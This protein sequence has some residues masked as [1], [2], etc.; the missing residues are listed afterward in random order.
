MDSCTR[1]RDSMENEEST[2]MSYELLQ[3]ITDNFSEKRLLGSGTF[4]MVYKGTYTNGK[5]I[6]VKVLRDMA[7]LDDKDFKNEFQNLAK[8]DH[9]NIVQLVGYCNES[10][11]HVVEQDGRQFTAQKLHKALCFEYVDNGSLNKYISDETQGLQWHIRYKIIKGICDGLKHLHKGLETPVLHLDLKPHN[12]LL[13]KEMVPKIADFGLSRIIGDERTRQTLKNDLGTGGYLPPEYT[14]FQLLSPAFDIFSLGIIITK[15]MVGKERYNDIADMQPRKLVKLVHNNW[16]KRLQEIVRPRSLEVY[17]QQVKTCIEVASKC[18]TEDRHGRPKIQEIINILNE[19]EMVNIPLEIEEIHEFRTSIPSVQTSER[20]GVEASRSSIS[21]EEV[22]FKLL[23]KITDGFSDARLIG[24]GSSG[25]VYKGIFEDEQVIAVRI[26]DYFGGN[27]DADWVIFRDEFYNLSRIKHENIVQL[28]AY[29]YEIEEKVVEYNGRMVLAEKDNIAL[30]WEYLQ[31]GSLD[32]Y[33]SDES[34]GL[35]WCTRYKIIRGTC[36]GLRYLHEVLEK[37]I[38]HLN[39]KP[40]NILLDANMVPKIG[41][42]CL[43]ILFHEGR[44]LEAIMNATGSLGYLPPEYINTGVI[45]NKHDIFSLGVMILEMVTGCR[46]YPVHHYESEKFIELILGKWRK[47]MQETSKGR[48]VKG[49]SRQVKRCMEIALTCIEVNRHKRPNIGDIVRALDETETWIDNDIELLDVHPLELHFPFKPKRHASCLLQL[50]NRQELSKLPK[51]HVAFRLVPESPQK[52]LSQLPLGGIVPPGC[53]Y[54]LALTTCKHPQRSALNS[55]DSFVLQSMA[56]RHCNYLDQASV[57]RECERIFKKA[58]ET[59]EGEVQEVTLKSLCAP[60]AEEPSSSTTNRLEIEIV[61]MLDAQRVSSVE[62]HPKKPWIMTTHQGGNLRVWNYDTLTIL[63]LVEVP[64]QP[65]HVARFIAREEWIVAGDNNG[66]IHVISYDEN[67]DDMSFN[68]HSGQIMSLAVHPTDSYI[69]SSSH[70]DH[71]I[72]LW[73]WDKFWDFNKGAWECTRT[74]EGHSN[75]VSQVVFNQDTCSFAST[76]WDGTVK[77]W[78]LNSDVCDATLDGHLDGLLCV[79]YITGGDRQYL[80]AGS[81]DGTAQI[82]DLEIKRRR[83]YLQGHANHISVVYSHHEHQKLITGSL[84]GTV[85]IWDATTFR[86][87]NII[88]FNLGAVSDVG[89]IEEL[90]RIVVGCHQG[91]A[92]MMVKFS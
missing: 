23:E 79:D 84:D 16:K 61:A 72:K 8:L 20:D 49:Y 6:A 64:D 58:R 14:K 36:N 25:R 46:E 87:E 15:I 83:E 81:M 54:I 31:N 43:S 66:S 13:D 91:I 65:V 67:K 48:S 40:S 89:Y 35:D 32:R 51:S 92:T 55:D 70:G 39:L 22:T 56:V 2:K 4:G 74:F 38:L 57:I 9:Q 69:L 30:C 63:S 1:S 24:R 60:Q 17:C 86:L 50:H 68:A 47:R 21:E 41:D 34:V 62:V 37:P 82:W 5:E 42:F 10:E 12:I 19:T 78:N 26:L 7:A 77:I 45:S 59:G 53:T 90:Q 28:L 52:Y 27:N 75:K 29:T 76:S 80:I 88:A 73:H 71:L 33:I 3:S 44:S 85:R 18:L 11:D